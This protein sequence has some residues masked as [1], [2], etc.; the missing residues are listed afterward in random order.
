MNPISSLLV[1][2][3]SPSPLI[4]NTPLA[5][6][7]SVGISRKPILNYDTRWFLS[8]FGAREIKSCFRFETPVFRIR[9]TRSRLFA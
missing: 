9:R 5:I 6:E 2:W 8:Y 1:F 7:M 3:A 4:S